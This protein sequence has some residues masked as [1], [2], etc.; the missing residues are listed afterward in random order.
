MMRL[1]TRP[2]SFRTSF[3]LVVMFAAVVPLALIGVW[4]TRSVVDAGED[5]LRSELDQSL[6]KIA[7]SVAERWSY[8]RGDLEL[9]A[10]N[11]VA[12]R[13]LAVGGSGPLAP[14]DA[15]YLAQLFASVS[16]AIPA[17]EYR[18][19]RD[20]LR[21]AS[22]APAANSTETPGQGQDIAASLASAADAM[23]TNGQR[24]SS[25]PAAPA[26]TVRLP[27]E[28]ATGRGEARLGDVIARL[29]LA[30]L[31]P[32]DT[33]VRLP[34]GARLQW[35]D[36]AT[37]QAL[38]PPFAPDSLLGRD[39]FTTA[40]VDW[41]AVHRSMTDPEVDLVLAAP[42]EAYVQPFEGVARTGVITLTVVALL[43]LALS[44]FLTTRLTSSLER[45]AVAADAVAGGDLAHRV[46]GRGAAEVGRVA[47]AFNSMTESLQRTL[48][49]LSKRQALA[50]AGEFAV[51]LSH[52][53][54]NGLTAVR[55]DLQRAE[56]KTAEGAPG[57]PL[58]ARAL[59][60]VKRLE[61]TV[62]GSLRVAR[63]GR[64]PHRRLDV[65]PVVAAAAQSAESTFTEHGSSLSP[66]ASSRSPAWVMG[67]AIALEQLLLNL[68]LNSAQ[69][70]APGGRA[71]LILDVDG[72]DVRIVVTDTGTGIAAEDLK[73]VLDPFFSTKAD[74][75]G[76][77][78]PIARQIA[79]AHGGSLTIES[80]P[81]NG[82]RV[83]VRLP[84]AASPS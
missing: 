73:Q 28:T 60:N 9:L 7:A 13:V 61:G 82:T 58:I 39:R 74:G 36:R 67:D 6:E 14:E 32:V 3:L 33:S 12:L 47:A 65:G 78:L 71:S 76:L 8:R 66:P 72:A 51:S 80:V 15:E 84:L 75:T 83:E 23:G 26:M 41:I 1:P 25:P 44:G 46:D 79:A 48:A 27:V 16:P 77:G 17:F 62:S 43:A 55:V 69:A 37:G 29:S 10:R 59:E 20:E 45:L 30:A 5:L 11:E 40:D 57:R 24:G 4:L 35:V 19:G 53:V 70:M 50:A 63:S 22:P 81:G 68:L 18:D 34:N 52:E 2:A 56:E 64:S 54:R 21:W 38:L 49:E 42:L 31:M